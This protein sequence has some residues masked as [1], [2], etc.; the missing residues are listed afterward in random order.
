MEETKKIKILICDDHNIVSQGLANYLISE[1]YIDS[2]CVCTTGK[3][4]LKKFQ[5]Q[6][7]DLAILD[8]NM[9]EMSGLRLTIELK[10]HYPQLKI[11]M[12]SM[13]SDLLTVKEC[14]SAGASGYLLKNEDI[15][16]IIKA[17]NIV[18][19]DKIYYS[20]EIEIGLN[21]DLENLNNL[22]LNEMFIT[23]REREILTLII[24]E[25]NSRQIAEKL[26]I[27]ENTVESHRKNIMRK[28]NTRTSIGLV[29]YAIERGLV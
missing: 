23:P 25:Y 9:D 8:V 21:K 3:E 14:M 26:F 7:F 2:I 10:L 17:I 20:K 18:L 5:S 27:S 24:K 22:S 11:L 28:T 15:N 29:T 19:N 13:R 1:P 16:Q 4:T 12:L 6:V